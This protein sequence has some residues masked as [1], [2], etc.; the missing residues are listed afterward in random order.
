[1]P[2]ARFIPEAVYFY[3]RRVS[4]NILVGLSDRRLSEVNLSARRVAFSETDGQLPLNPVF[5]AI[6]FLA[7]DLGY[8]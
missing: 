6:G 7:A 1:M 4:P 2:R 8:G 3:T 5:R